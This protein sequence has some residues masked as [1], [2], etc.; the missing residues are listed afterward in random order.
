MCG[1]VYDLG[2]ALV[3]S[4]GHDVRVLAPYDPNAT[5]A[6]EH[7]E[8]ERVRHP[9]PLERRLDA[10]ADLGDALGASPAAWL[11]AAPFVAS[12]AAR[13][14]RAARWADVVC[15]HWLVPSGFAATFAGARPHIAVAHGGDV[16][17][18]ARIPLGPRITRT[19]AARAARLVAVSRDLAQRLEALA[20]GAR[21]DVVPMGAEIGPPPDPRE[22]ALLREDLGAGTRPVVLFLGRLVGVKGVDVLLEAA[23]RSPEV[24]VWIAGDGPDFERLRDRA[25]AA[26]LDVSFLGRIDRRRRRL[27]LE[28]CDAVVVPSRIERAGRAEGAPVVCFES[29]AAGKPVIAT[30]TGGL[31]EIIEDDSTGLLVPPDDAG[32]L[33]AALRHFGADA[34]LRE[35]LAA[36]AAARAGGASMAATA[37]RFDEIIR[38]VT[39]T[40]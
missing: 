16:H 8:V 5:G 22:I 35:R 14:R 36:G 25:A 39:T 20:P 40:I 37:R 15:S 18:L 24:A 1:Y 12:F 21:V 2:R 29:Y 30:R 17:L 13:A 9:W 28:A 19:I 27:A 7:V 32:A 3:V 34:A 4:H 6:F 23:A 38:E 31:V 33:T 26:R 10:G 11:E